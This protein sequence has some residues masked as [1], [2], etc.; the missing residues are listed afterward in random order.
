MQRFT[1]VGLTIFV[2][3]AVPLAPASAL[4]KVVAT[5]HYDNLRTGWNRSETILTPANVGPSTFGVLSKVVLDDQVD[6]QPLVVPSQQIIAGSFTLGS[7]GTYEVVYVATEANTVYAINSANGAV[8]AK[9]LSGK[10]IL[11]C[12]A[13][14]T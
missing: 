9:S 2:A 11:D 12:I 3:I 13:F 6:A 1:I 10:I 7:P 5:Y 4:S 14:L 8:L